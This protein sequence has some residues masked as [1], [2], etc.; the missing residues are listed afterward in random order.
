MGPE[1]AEQE[2]QRV[3]SYLL[4]V[5]SSEEENDER[6][7]LDW[8][9]LL[10]EAKLPDIDTTTWDNAA[11]VEK[12]REFMAKYGRAFALAGGEV[13]A[14]ETPRS[15]LRREV[16][17]ET[18]LSIP[19]GFFVLLAVGETASTVDPTRSQTSYLFL[20]FYDEEIM[21][22]PQPGEEVAHVPWGNM[23]EFL[24][25]SDVPQEVQ[26]AIRIGLTFLDTVTHS[27]DNVPLVA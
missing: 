13:K 3:A 17:E 16:Q 14:D 6:D 5:R 9:M 11:V 27:T 20:A 4:L 8:E 24:E 22:I 1:H 25:R 26:L 12:L 18:Q 21:G 23:H 15:G 7:P 2:R 19:S 10:V